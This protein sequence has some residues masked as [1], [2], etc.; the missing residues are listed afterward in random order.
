L[1][2]VLVPNME[3]LAA[4][5]LGS[6]YRYIYAQHLNYFTAQTLTR[7]VAGGFS[8]VEMRST[9]FNPVIIWQDW[10]RGGEEVSN[11]QRAELLQRTT[12]YKQNPL[13]RPVKGFY[14]LVERALGA[15]YLADN[16]VVVLRRRG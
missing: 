5:L 16:L 7:L 10:R 15:C 1:C 8:I 11:Q 4:R 6:K 2:F 9:H 14:K 12:A 13:L 3:S